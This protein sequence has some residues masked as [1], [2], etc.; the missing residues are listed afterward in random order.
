MP[1]KQRS[2]FEMSAGREERFMAAFERALAEAEAVV[3]REYESE[4]RPRERLRAGLAALLEF[5]D[6]DPAAAR[7]LV[8]DALRAGPAAAERRTEVMEELADV[9]HGEG[10]RAMDPEEREP[11]SLTEQGVVNAVFGLIHARVSAPDWGSSNGAGPRLASLLG[12][13]MAIVLLP[14]LGS[15]AAR[16]ELSAPQ[17]RLQRTGRQRGKTGPVVQA[18]TA[19]KGVPVRLTEL[20][21]CTIAAIAAINEEGAN[22]SNN[23]IC[24]ATGDTN[25]GQMSRLLQRLDRLGLIEN[26]SNNG[27]GQGGSNAWRLTARGRALARAH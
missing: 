21:R 13:L 17:L 4:Q 25:K 2:F 1:V 10:V 7:V 5:F 27:N 15:R 26:V 14:Y 11:P 20:T 24:W 9:I 22:P 8:V 16:R 12:P 18:L 6:R 3:L 23:D 19:P